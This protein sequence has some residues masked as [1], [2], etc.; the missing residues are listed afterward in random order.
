[1]A[2]LAFTTSPK[3]FVTPLCHSRCWYKPVPQVA[4]SRDIVMRF[5]LSEWLKDWYLYRRAM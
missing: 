3:R 4:P 5:R 2:N 1:V